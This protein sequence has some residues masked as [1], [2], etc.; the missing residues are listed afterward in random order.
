MI[1]D[2][3]VDPALVLLDPDP[4]PV[5]VPAPTPV[6]APAPVP[7]PVPIDEFVEEP[8]DTIG[9]TAEGETGEF[10]DPDG[11]KTPHKYLN[12]TQIITIIYSRKLTIYQ[13]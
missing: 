8:D 6:P 11:V 4:V 2:W 5:P 1:D 9:S 12:N 3:V 7:A 13:R 10:V